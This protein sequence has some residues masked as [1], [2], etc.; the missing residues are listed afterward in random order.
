VNTSLI[1]TA[2][3]SYERCCQSDEFLTSF[4]EYLFEASE[5]AK[6]RFADT[7]FKVLIPLMKHAI[8]LLLIFSTQ[9][10]DQ[11]PILDRIATRHT[12]TDLGV[13]PELYPHWVNALMRAV[14]QY[15][16]N[17]E[18]GVEAAWREVLAPGIDYMIARYNA[19]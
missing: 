18:P 15:D 11:T 2:K 4:Y 3:A 6:A 1:D 10:D 8:G 9:A 19:S 7:D 16:A 13:P 14:R 5:E 12:K 17:F